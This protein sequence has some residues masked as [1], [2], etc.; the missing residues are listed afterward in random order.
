MAAPDYGIGLADDQGAGPAENR[1][2]SDRIEG[3]PGLAPL[4]RHDS[5]QFPAARSAPATDEAPI[6]KTQTTDTRATCIVNLQAELCQMADENLIYDHESS[7]GEPE[8]LSP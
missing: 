3:A 2:R 7:P 1:N 8:R 4:S 5:E 6:A